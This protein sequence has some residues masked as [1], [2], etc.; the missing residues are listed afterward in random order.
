MIRPVAISFD[1]FVEYGR[2]TMKPEELVNGMPWAFTFVGHPVTHENDDL[3]LVGNGSLKF[4]RGTFMV[5]T[6][7]N[8]VFL[9]D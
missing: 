2:T 7:K 6:E 9:T 3:Y 4:S 5:A 8:I 1:E